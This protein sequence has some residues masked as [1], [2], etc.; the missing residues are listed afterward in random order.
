[1]GGKGTLPEIFFQ[2]MVQGTIFATPNRG[3]SKLRNSNYQRDFRNEDVWAPNI[4]GGICK[5]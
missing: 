2:E 5:L 3:N 4:R 1:L